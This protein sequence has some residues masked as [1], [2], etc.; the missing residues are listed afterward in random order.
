MGLM[1]ADDRAL[2]AHSLRQATEEHSGVALD[3]VLAHLGWHDAL[4]EHKGDAVAL[5]FELQGKANTA[6]AALDDVLAQSLGVVSG[7]AIVLPPLG[8]WHPP[9]RVFGDRLHVHGV[10][11]AAFR[12]RKRAVAV[13]EQD[14]THVA[15]IPAA[16]ARLPGGHRHRPRPRPDGGDG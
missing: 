6:S 9:A 10:A 1:D 14:G 12:D 4:D 3:T 15:E 16:A 7:A 5:L 13:W 8:R 11:T 2:F